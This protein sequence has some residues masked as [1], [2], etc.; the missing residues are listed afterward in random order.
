M[1]G[2]AQV[3]APIDIVGAITELTAGAATITVPVSS[4][5]VPMPHA[6]WRAAVE[7][8]SD[9]DGTVSEPTAGTATFTV[10]I[11]VLP[12]AFLAIAW[13]DQG[14]GEGVVDMSNGNEPVDWD[15]GGVMEVKVTLA[16]ISGDSTTHCRVRI[17]GD[18]V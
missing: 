6:H 1:T 3:L 18:G 5:V 9:A 17:R 7:F 15:A 14:A 16:G 4:A 13:D 2:H 11:G 10:K 8:Y 12:N